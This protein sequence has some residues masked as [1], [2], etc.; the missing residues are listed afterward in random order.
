M[1]IILLTELKGRGG[2]GDVIEVKTGFAVNYLFPRKMAIEATPG[3]L[4]QLEQRM[5]NIKKREDVRLAE[6]GDF[7]SLLDGKKVVISMKVG[8]A[9]RL[10]GSVTP[11]MIADAI[12]EQLG[13]EVDRR[14]IE[15]R[16]VIKT[17]GTHSAEIAVYR[18]IKADFIIE[19]AAEG[20]ATEVSEEE[21]A[22]AAEVE[23]AKAGID[24]SDEAEGE[25]VEDG[26][27]ETEAG[28]EEDASGE[29]VVEVAVEETI[30]EEAPE[31]E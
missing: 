5:H 17:I 28:A 4:K 18:D 21:A 15:T 11:M 16:G 30:A 19:V 23:A 29:E 9:G 12:K 8:D 26:T 20:E 6:A 3:N 24:P 27:V 1:K 31:K 7:S 14:K 10:F 25:A 22:L 13:V 2:E